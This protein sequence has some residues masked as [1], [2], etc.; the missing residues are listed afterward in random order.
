MLST[1]T[2]DHSKAGVAP[3]DQKTATATS[4]SETEDA[5][6]TEEDR[7]KDHEKKHLAKPLASQTAMVTTDTGKA[8]RRSRKKALLKAQKKIV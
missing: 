3:G 6:E 1:A 4:P 5:S 8:A 7:R 2:Q